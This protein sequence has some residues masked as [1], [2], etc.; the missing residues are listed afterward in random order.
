[1]QTHQIIDAFKAAMRESGIEP[2][3]CIEADGVLHRFHIAG[4]KHGSLNGAY[5]L[6]LDGYKPAGYFEDFKTGFKT[7]W[8]AGGQIQPLTRAER[9]QMEA[10]K[11]LSAQQQQ[12]RNQQAAETARRLWAQARDVSG[13]NHPYLIRKAV[14]AYGLKLCPVW[15]KRINQN[16]AWLNVTAKNV[17]LVPLLDMRGELHNVQAIFAEI[18]PALGRD[19]DF[20]AGGRSVGLFHA[21]GQATGEKIICEGYATGASLF[22]A[23]GLQVFCALS[24]RNLIK[25]AKNLRAAHP[26][27]TL[28]IAADNDTKKPGNPGLKAAKAAARAVGG[29]LAVP[30][31]PGDFNDYA[32]MEGRV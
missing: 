31:V 23:T 25:V 7:N 11:R 13:R 9:E 2:P 26:G 15:A 27:D 16:G 14:D 20:L 12:A 3:D 1:M 30:P 24:D 21:I 29:L 19:K 6:H 18:E 10:C 17:L 28:I 8:K 4:H 22:K 32:A 5:K